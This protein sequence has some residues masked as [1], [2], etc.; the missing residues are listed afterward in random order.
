[1]R[2]SLQ[3]DDEIQ[4]TP[5]ASQ[6]KDSSTESTV[7]DDTSTSTSLSVQSQSSAAEDN[8]VVVQPVV[9]RQRNRRPQDEKRTMRAMALQ[10]CY[11]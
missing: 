8:Q 10:L 11:E 6:E 7:L 3:C 9:Y 4:D 1:M 5:L 2:S